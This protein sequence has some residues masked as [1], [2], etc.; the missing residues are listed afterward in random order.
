MKWVVKTFYELI[1]LQSK[2][3]SKTQKL[4]FKKITIKLLVLIIT[5][6]TGIKLKQFLL[7]Y[8]F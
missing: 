6:K 1:K 4:Y 8:M 7:F 2:Q 5:Y 3:S